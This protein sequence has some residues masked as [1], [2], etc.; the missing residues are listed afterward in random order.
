MKACYFLYTDFQ[1][2]EWSEPQLLV[3]EHNGCSGGNAIKG[4]CRR[5]IGNGTSMNA[6]TIQWLLDFENGF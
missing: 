2:T 6:W 3:A 4:D 1:N 5:N